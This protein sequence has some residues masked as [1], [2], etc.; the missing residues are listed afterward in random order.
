[1][2]P[3]KSSETKRLKDFKADSVVVLI[4]RMKRRW[5]VRIEQPR[6]LA[7]QGVV[8]VKAPEQFEE[9]TDRKWFAL[10][11]MLVAVKGKKPLQ[12][13]GANGDEWVADLYPP[14]VVPDASAAPP[15]N[16][17]NDVPP[18]PQ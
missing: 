11:P 17:A 6:E 18:V 16:P 13:D 9:M 2:T 5:E 12:A 10:N 4:D 3:R 15:V 14:A 7:T 8:I 1:M